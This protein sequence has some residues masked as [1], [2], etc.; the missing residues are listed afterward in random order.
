M[1]RPDEADE[2]EEQGSLRRRRRPSSV[3]SVQQLDDLGRSQLISETVRDINSSSNSP[4][5]AEEFTLLSESNHSYH[6]IKSYKSSALAQTVRNK[7]RQWDG[8]SGV[9]S[10]WVDP[11]ARSS[12]LS[13]LQFF[14]ELVSSECMKTNIFV[15]SDTAT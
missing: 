10:V 9:Y 15:V 6:L 11:P 5:A 12:P 7:I 8:R 3:N 14:H 1:K 13:L 4:V 2:E